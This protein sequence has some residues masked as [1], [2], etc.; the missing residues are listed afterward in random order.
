VHC[1]LRRRAGT[2]VEVGAVRRALGI[3]RSFGILQRLK[4][5]NRKPQNWRADPQMTSILRSYFEDDVALLG[6]LTGRDLSHWL[7]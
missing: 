4:R 3:K 6:R 7:R 2:A 5:W 1:C